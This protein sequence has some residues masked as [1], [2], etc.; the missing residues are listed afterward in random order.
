MCFLLPSDLMNNIPKKIIPIIPKNLLV[1]IGTP[2]TK[3]F[4]IVDQ[5]NCEY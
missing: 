2:K 1:S 5:T 3:K 4:I